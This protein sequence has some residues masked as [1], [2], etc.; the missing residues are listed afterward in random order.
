MKYI[1]TTSPVPG[2]NQKAKKFA[3]I[4]RPPHVASRAF[5]TWTGDTPTTPYRRLN[6]TTSYQTLYRSR[7]NRANRKLVKQANGTIVGVNP[8]GTLAA[9]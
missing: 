4:K 2:L 8:N 9:A 5:T 6:A 3:T 7:R 1:Y